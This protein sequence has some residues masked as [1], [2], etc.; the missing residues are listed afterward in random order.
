MRDMIGIPQ[1]ELQ[2]MPSS[3]Q[4]DRC[5]RLAASKME[6]MS[7]VGNWLVHRRQGRIN[8]KMMVSGVCFIDT[9]WRNAH[10]NQTKADG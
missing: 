1:K 6:V 2:G 3:G 4:R 5:L 7:V 9:R 8:Q 10:V